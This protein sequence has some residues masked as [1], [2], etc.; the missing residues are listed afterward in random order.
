MIHLPPTHTS[1]QYKSKQSQRKEN[2]G[3]DEKSDKHLAEGLDGNCP[4]EHDELIK[5]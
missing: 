1:C 4:N 3:E 2:Y 5:R